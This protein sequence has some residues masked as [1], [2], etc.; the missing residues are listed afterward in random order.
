[1]MDSLNTAAT[2][3]LAQQTAIDVV[4]NNLANVTTTGFKRG[5]MDAVDLAYQAFQLPT[6]SAGQ[7]GLG[8]G[9]G[10]L[11]KEMGRQGT[12][13]DTGRDL[14]VAI[15][16]EGLIQVTQ[17]NGK[18]AYTRA[19]NLQVDAN[20]RLALTGG[21]L[22]Q[23]RVTIPADAT[24]VT[25]A[26]DGEVSATVAGQ[27]KKLGTIDLALFVNPAGLEAIGDNMFVATPNSG[28]AKLAAAGSGGRGLLE[29]GKLEGSNVDVA[30]E[31]ITMIFA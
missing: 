16:G 29:Q 23:P 24:G 19:G 22:L 30:T 28:Q 5:R 12:F 1:M 21:Q 18:L 4:A 3:M 2:G 13:Q 7:I 14:D 9:P 10:Q 25:I 31:M 11:A 15:N 26:P 6:G 17:A 20:G 8:A 27:I